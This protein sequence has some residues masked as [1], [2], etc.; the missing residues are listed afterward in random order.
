MKFQ[1]P[2]IARAALLQARFYA[3]APQTAA[4]VIDAEIETTPATQLDIEVLSAEQ[5]YLEYDAFLTANPSEYCADAAERAAD[6]YANWQCLL[7]YQAKAVPSFTVTTQPHPDHGKRGSVTVRNFSDRADAEA[8]A[9]YFGRSTIVARPIVP[10]AEC[11]GHGSDGPKRIHWTNPNNIM[12]RCGRC[13]GDGEEP[14]LPDY[15]EENYPDNDP[16][17]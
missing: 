12:M 16:S 1:H 14:E 4:P 15:D 2:A 3:H 8:Y 5:E 17:L 7:A 6:F 9:D 11:G 13:G 10:C